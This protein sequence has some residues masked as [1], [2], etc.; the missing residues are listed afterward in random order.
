MF[1]QIVSQNIANLRAEKKLTQEELAFFAGMQISQWGKCERG[2]GNPT[3]S[4][5]RR[6]AAALGVPLSRMFNEGTEESPD[7][8]QLGYFIRDCMPYTWD[9]GS[10]YDPLVLLDSTGE[11]LLEKVTLEDM[12]AAVQR[13]CQCI[14][15]RPITRKS[16]NKK[17]GL[18]TG[19]CMEYIK[20]AFH[21]VL[22]EIADIYPSRAVV[23]ELAEWLT[24][25]RPCP[26]RFREII[27]KF[28]RN[29]Y[30]LQGI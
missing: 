8:T 28:R 30:S 2:E 14:V 27:E 17:G 6:I 19:I 1:R 10:L 24:R 7:Y 16:K 23:E 21:F 29:G 11:I 20:G 3:L 15:Y 9:L 18:S 22:D 13:Y 5:L 25:K 26:D 4:T 12:D